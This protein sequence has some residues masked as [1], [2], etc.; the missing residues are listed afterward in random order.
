MSL[1]VEAFLRLI[2]ISQNALIVD[3][4]LQ[5]LERLLR[6]QE[7]YQIGEDDETHVLSQMQSLDGASCIQ[8]CM[9][10]HSCK[11]LIVKSEMIY[12]KLI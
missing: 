12:E 2:K 7:I 1:V 10:K 8:S 3:E 6:M 5:A 4:V 9:L 11:D